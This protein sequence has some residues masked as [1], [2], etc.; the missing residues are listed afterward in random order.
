MIVS[1]QIRVTCGRV[2]VTS[3]HV[4]AAYNFAIYYCRTAIVI[5]VYDHI[6]GTLVMFSALCGHVTVA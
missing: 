3:G 4:T 1:C 5:V 6:M 2:S